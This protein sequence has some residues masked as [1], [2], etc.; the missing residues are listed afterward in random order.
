MEEADRLGVDGT[1]SNVQFH[2]VIA[3]SSGNT[4]L[5]DFMTFLNDKVSYLSL[6]DGKQLKQRG[7]QQT[8]HKEHWAICKAIES[9]DDVLARKAVQNHIQNAA[10]RQGI[11]IDPIW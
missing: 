8:V 6:L 2:Q 5:K 3:E 1:T 11:V 4:Y 7:S 10:K 9:R